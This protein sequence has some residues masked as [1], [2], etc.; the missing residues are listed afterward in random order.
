MDIII[1]IIS[2]STI[3]NIAIIIVIITVQ[4]LLTAYLYHT[5]TSFWLQAVGTKIGVGGGSPS[6]RP[7]SCCA[8][9]HPHDQDKA[10]QTGTPLASK[11]DATKVRLLQF[12]PLSAQSWS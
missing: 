8:A 11:A 10:V 7:A 12:K 4:F 5:C 1:F 9:A 6:P 2:I 3:F